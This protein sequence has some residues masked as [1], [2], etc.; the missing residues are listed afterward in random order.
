MA[1]D[2]AFLLKDNLTFFHISRP[3]DIGKRVKI[4]NE[5]VHLFAGKGRELDA[6][7][8][9]PLVH[10]GK[11]DPHLAG[12]LAD[13]GLQLGSAALGSLTGVAVVT[14]SAPFADKEGFTLTRISQAEKFSPGVAIGL[15]NI[16]GQ[17]H[18]LRS[19]EGRGI[20]I[21]TLKRSHHLGPVVPHAL[22]EEDRSRWVLH[23]IEPGS[24]LPTLIPHG[25]TIDAFFV[26]PQL[27]AGGKIAGRI[28]IVQEIKK[29][30]KIK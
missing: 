26:H 11:V 8:G 21:Q 16:G 30:N 3:A 24:C 9:H 12:N 19:K 23:L 22:G 28:E 4:G 15:A 10:T 18:H 7:A 20:H 1:L 13:T 2:T 27:A 6:L 14:G 29:G 25:V 5:V 17:V